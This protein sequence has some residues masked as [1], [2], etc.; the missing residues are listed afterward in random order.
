MTKILICGYGSIGK[1]H[2]VNLKALGVDIKIWRQQIE[3]APEIEADGYI[4]E[5]ALEDGLQWCDGVVIATNTNQ[6]IELANLAAAMGK[7]IYIEKPLSHDREGIEQLR[8]ASKNLVVEIGCQLRQHPVLRALYDA[9]REGKDG[10]VLTFQAWVGQRLDQWRPGTDYRQS[11]SADKSRG[12]GALFDLVHEID[13]MTW[14]V[15]TMDSVYADLRHNSDLEMKAEDLANLILTA[16]NGAAGTV[17]LDMLSPAYR[18][19][20]QII[21]EK[22]IYRYDLAEG[23]L[24]HA[25]GT[26]TQLLAQIPQG[27]ELSQMLY[28]A[29]ANFVARIQ[30]PSRPSHCTLEEGIHDLDILL[31]AR[32][33]D[34]AGARQTIAGDA[35]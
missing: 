1:K 7:A 20:G 21:C 19:G 14:L 5:E 35:S 10:K 28:D 33:S 15:G 34:E 12:G 13:L 32:K 25:Q 11:Y 9:V 18:R 6:H 2:A 8:A 31:A 17:Q 30:E 3:C 24:W 22:A 23:K 26:D 27:Y 16:Q 29:M 4:F